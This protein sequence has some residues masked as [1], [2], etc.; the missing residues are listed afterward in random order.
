MAS[1]LVMLLLVINYLLS[2]AARACS[3]VPSSVPG[4]SCLV[5]LVSRR[6][7]RDNGHLLPSGRIKL[8]RPSPPPLPQGPMGSHLLVLTLHPVSPLF[9]LA[10]PGPAPRLLSSSLPPPSPNPQTLPQH[11]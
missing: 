4:R 10:R 3:V 2:E 11:T 9:T 7:W 8:A 5:W 6:E 1:L